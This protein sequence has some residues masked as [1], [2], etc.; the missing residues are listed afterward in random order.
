MIRVMVVDDSPLVRKIA[1]DILNS[2]PQI[3]VI[4]TAAKAEFALNKLERVRPDVITMDIEMPGIGGLAAIREIMRSRPVPTIVLSAHAKRGAELTLQ[5]LEAGAVDFM[6]KPTPSLSGGLDAVARELIEKVKS[7]C[8]IDLKPTEESSKPEPER[9]REN[10]SERPADVLSSR[11]DLVAIG[12]STGGPVALKSVL[13]V[14]PESFPLPIVVVQHMPPLFTKAFAERL[15]G[16]CVLD[17]KE[18]EDG[19]PI[20]PGQ[21]LI[22]PGNYHMVVLRNSREPLVGLN[23]REL[24]CGHRPSVDVLMHSV[25][26]EYG[27]QAIAVIMTGMGRDGAAGIREL[28]KTG[29]YVVAQDKETSVIFGMNREVILNGDADAVVPLQRISDHLLDCVYERALA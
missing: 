6:L 11:F 24:V 27:S 28:R 10:R 29:G 22:A 14:L 17:V 23:Q 20:L 4:A 3:E 5:A 13:S 1:S 16:T 26:K 19:D 9:R 2:D 12:T 8:S 25:A 18:A 7:A 15:N 21:V